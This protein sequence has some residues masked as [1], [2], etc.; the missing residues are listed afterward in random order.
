LKNE[1][2]LLPIRPSVRKIAVIGPN[3]NRA[4][5]GGGGSASLNPYYNT[6]P[7]SS[8]KNVAG[9]EVIYAQ[10]CDIFKWMP[11]AT[12]FC[13]TECG[14]EGV[15]IEFFVGD[16]FDGKPLVIQRRSNTD[17]MLWDSVPV[18]VGTI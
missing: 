12:P 6:L 17:L 1:G 10:G 4:V 5:A 3:A 14:E 16:E 9:H 13:T 7:L 11:L 18:E 2:D 15:I 8:I